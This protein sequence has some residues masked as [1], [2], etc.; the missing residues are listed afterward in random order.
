MDSEQVNKL[1]KNIPEVAAAYEYGV[2]IAALIANMKRPV[3]E[4][5]RRHQ[6]ALDTFQKLRNAKKL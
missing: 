2:D 3:A 4:R 5:I 1:V 6:I